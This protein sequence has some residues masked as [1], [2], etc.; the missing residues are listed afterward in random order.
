M[1]FF[2]RLRQEGVPIAAGASAEMMRTVEIVGLAP[3]GDVFYALRALCCTS[4]EQYDRFA[5]V[6]VDY[7]RQR[8][9]AGIAFT[10]PREREWV[11]SGEDER[12]G[13]GEGEES[14]R[15]AGGQAMQSACAT[16]IS[17]R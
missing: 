10:Q 4:V 3:P 11:I 17:P 7:F 16:R 9:P 1:G 15:T 13:D 14:I 12:D 6:F 2:H 5:T 8:V